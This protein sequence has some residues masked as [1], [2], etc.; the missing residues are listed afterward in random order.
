MFSG[1]GHFW[2]AAAKN[3]P[4]NR[5][6]L[7][8]LEALGIEYPPQISVIG[9]GPDGSQNDNSSRRRPRGHRYTRKILLSHSYLPKGREGCEGKNT[10]TLGCD[11]Q[12]IHSLS[13]AIEPSKYSYL[14]EMMRLLKSPPLPS[15]ICLCKIMRVKGGAYFSKE[16]GIYLSAIDTAQNGLVNTLA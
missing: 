14:V 3:R 8:F 4:H 12:R 1:S 11:P 15:S 7:H 2:D 6:V 5:S 9:G 13:H 16:G 10:T